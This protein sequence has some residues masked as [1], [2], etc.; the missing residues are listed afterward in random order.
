M[1]IPRSVATAALAASLL[2]FHAQADD[3]TL[4]FSA[5]PPVAGEHGMV[6]SVHRIASQVGVDILKKGGNAVDAAVAVGYALAVVYP[7][8]GNIGGGGFMTLR[9]ADGHE[10]FLDFR[11]RAPLAA[12][13][14]MYLDAK[15]DV[16][17]NLSTDGWLSVGVPGTV[18]GLETARRR[19][20]TMTR[21]ALLAP[22][23]ALAK[24]GFVLASD[25]TR[26]VGSAAV[27]LLRGHQDVFAQFTKPDGTPYA[28]GD[29][30]VQPKL[31]VTL[32]RIAEFGPYAFY[33]GPIADQI[34][35]ASAAGHGI[36][37]KADLRRYRV[38]ELAP[39]TCDYRGYHIISSP[40]PSS[41][42]VALCEMLHIV[43]GFPIEKMPFHSVE[44]VHDL[45]EAMRLAFADRN[46]VLGDPAFVKNPVAR[47]IDPAYAAKLRAKIDPEK[48]GKSTVPAAAPQE[49]NNTTHYSIVDKAGNAV[50]V[51][52][53]LNNYYG[54]RVMAGNT[55]VV[56]NDEMD[57][58]TS[59]P[60][61]PNLFGLVQG[62][63]NAI[64]P[65]KTP[66]SS[67]CPTIVT[68]GGHVVMVLG[69]PGGPRIIT[70]VF[71][72]IVNVV[73]HDMNI[74]QATAAPRLHHQ[75]LPDTLFAEPG[76]L[77]P[78]VAAALTKDG[79]TVDARGPWR[80]VEAIQVAPPHGGTQ[81][82]LL[83]AADQREPSSTA[84]GY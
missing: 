17:P 48:A 18:M 83:G 27:D 53:T 2:A 47:L 29:R 23:I 1:A 38:R 80:P 76:A 81:A 28:A 26:I 3:Q 8:A 35:A 5:P 56:M 77:A 4:S 40:P 32:R 46:N 25:D 79:Y 43:E 67:M 14:K 34:V 19:W 39:V 44:E 45:T 49:G 11:E 42:G 13:E 64:A 54:A 20:G 62:Q 7:E 57:D 37:T 36:I 63:I 59:K 15:G 72:S 60:G 22:A 71:E 50:S 73:D 31:A 66:L 16:V 78:D 75:W 84:I 9:L 70:S 68:R 30:L 6:V 41:G 24:S 51:T 74:S 55:G 21:T 69:S 52:Y 65:G 33:E 82:R 61:V 58:F 10:T 12:T